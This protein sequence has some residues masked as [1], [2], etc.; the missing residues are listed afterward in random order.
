VPVPVPGSGNTSVKNM[1]AS[2]LGVGRKPLQERDPQREQQ[3]RTENQ[4][5]AGSLDHRADDVQV[6][7]EAG[8]YLMKRV[9]TFSERIAAAAQ[10]FAE[11]LQSDARNEVT[12]LERAGLDQCSEFVAAYK[13][14]QDA[15]LA[16]ASVVDVFAQQ[17]VSAV[18]NPLTDAYREGDAKRKTL[19]ADQVREQ[20]DLTKL[21]DQLARTNS[22]CRAVWTQ[23]QSQ[24]RENVRAR[25]VLGFS[26]PQEDSANNSNA[27]VVSAPAFLDERI[28]CKALTALRKN[29]KLVQ[30]LRDKGAKEFS[31]CVRDV[32]QT[33]AAQERFHHSVVPDL[34]REYE[35]LERSRLTRIREALCTYTTLFAKLSE[36]APLTRQFSSAARD[37]DVRTAMQAY[38]AAM[39]TEHGPPPGSQPARDELPCAPDALVGDDWRLSLDVDFG[40]AAEAMSAPQVYRCDSGWAPSSP[41]ANSLWLPKGAYVLVTNRMGSPKSTKSRNSTGF[42][43]SNSAPRLASGA[44]SLTAHLDALQPSTPIAA[45]PLDVD[46]DEMFGELIT[47]PKH[48]IAEGTRP[49][50]SEPLTP[51]SSDGS[52]SSRFT[53][54]GFFPSHAVAKVLPDDSVPLAYILCCPELLA[55]FREHLASEFSLENLDF[56]AASRSFR[57][58][59]DSVPSGSEEAEADTANMSTQALTIMREYVFDDA[60]RQVNLRGNIQMELL[61]AVD[62]SLYHPL[63]FTEAEEEIYNLLSRD[64]LSRFKKSAKFCEKIRSASFD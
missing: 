53:S 37:L 63:M 61:D 1:L 51:T 31:K 58:T 33:R 10:K 35:A 32:E 60:P 50:S 12:H 17:V 41:R 29:E 44:G 24:E 46:A 42:T 15:T 16:F 54:R 39:R 2:F 64:S 7:V 20:A 55:L 8:M 59:W 52:T 26:C 30:E 34:M 36:S 56:W 9:G 28:R 21:E 48:R 19:R 38:V 43:Y 5:F 49:T 40:A 57:T 4:L 47:T 62:K 6:Q 18:A 11:Q 25:E 27:V 13:Q 14:M 22:K 23:I 45:D 3:L